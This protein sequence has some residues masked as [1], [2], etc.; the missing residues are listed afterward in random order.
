M[1]QFIRTSPQRPTSLLEIPNRIK[2]SQR[3]LHKP[4]HIIDKSETKI[5]EKRMNKLSRM[6]TVPI[7]YIVL[8]RNNQASERAKKSR[9]S[10]RS[11]PLP[12]KTMRYRRNSNIIENVIENRKPQ[13]FSKTQEV[14][15]PYTDNFSI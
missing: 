2:V 11:R 6:Q 4:E 9:S 7:K 14:F 1:M 5:L 12:K 13:F 3:L 15:F 8:N 10:I